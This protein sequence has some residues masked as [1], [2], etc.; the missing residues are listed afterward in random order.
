VVQLSA[1][2][3]VTDRSQAQAFLNEQK[4]DSVLQEY[5]RQAAADKGNFSVYNGHAGE[6]AMPVT[7]RESAAQYL[8]ELRERMRRAADDVALTSQQKQEQYANARAKS[9]NVGDRCLMFGTNMANKLS[10]RW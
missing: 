1:D 5:C 9:F 10:P 7:I 3:E 8:H 6:Y 4:G 2:E